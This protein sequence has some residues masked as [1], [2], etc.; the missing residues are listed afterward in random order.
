VKKGI[1]PG[2]F[3]HI[4][5]SFFIPDMVYVDMD[6]RCPRFFGDP[7]IREYIEQCKEYSGSSR[8]CFFHRDFT[9]EITGVKKDRDLLISL[10]AGFVSQHCDTYLKKGGILVANNSHGD[11]SLGFLDPSF[12]FIGVTKRKGPRFVF[13]NRDLPSY[14]IQKNGKPLDKDK[15][16]STMKG[17]VYTKTAYSYLFRKIKE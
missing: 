11:A 10:Y 17:P 13:D 14:F 16:L 7:Q 5:P 15:I 2:S 6:K 9:R 12:S 1:Y 8:F 4:T 3:V